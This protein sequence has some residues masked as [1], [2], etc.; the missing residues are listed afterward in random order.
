MSLSQIKWTKI[1]LIPCNLLK[2]II[3]NVLDI[4]ILKAVKCLLIEQQNVINKLINEQVLSLNNT[5]HMMTTF[6]I[7]IHSEIIS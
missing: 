1:H 5:L 7:K 4:V 3:F 2:K 6:V